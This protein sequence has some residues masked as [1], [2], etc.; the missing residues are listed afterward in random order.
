[1]F[2]NRALKGCS[3]LVNVIDNFMQTASEFR[4]FVFDDDFTVRLAVNK[5]FNVPFKLFFRR[6]FIRPKNKTVFL[7]T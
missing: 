6:L 1:M 3:A 7:R 2:F 5:S 4:L